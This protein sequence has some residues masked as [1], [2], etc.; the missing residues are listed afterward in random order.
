M[1]MKVQ[2]KFFMI[3][4]ARF[5]FVD[6][7]IKWIRFVGDSEFYWQVEELEWNKSEIRLH[8]LSCSNSA[9]CTKKYFLR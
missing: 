4:D 7:F 5:V 6:K 3:T 2:S 9:H 8:N 1:F